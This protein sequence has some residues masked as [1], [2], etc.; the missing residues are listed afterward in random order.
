MNLKNTQKSNAYNAIQQMLIDGSLPP[1][2]LVSEVSLAAKTGY[3]RTPIR[4]AISILEHE[5]LVS[6]LPRHGTIV[7]TPDIA[8]ITHYYDV[9]EALECF[10]A[11]RAA[12][13]MHPEEHAKLEITTRKLKE[14]LIKMRSDKIQVLDGELLKAA[15]ACDLAF[16]MIIIR[17]EH[18]P[19]ILKIIDNSRTFIRICNIKHNSTFRIMAHIYR[20]HES[21]R[22]A[23]IKRNPELA[24]HRMSKHIQRSRDQS[25]ATYSRH[26]TTTDVLRT[27]DD[28]IAND[29]FHQIQDLL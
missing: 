19:Q 11:A 21:I 20:D 8:E 6:R 3:G 25:I 15:L 18:N 16:H 2:S 12:S 26:Q 23:I 17:N 4:E 13:S 10:C 28:N 27:M 22:R 24:S 14:I 7:N 29:I 9:R 1:G 5:G